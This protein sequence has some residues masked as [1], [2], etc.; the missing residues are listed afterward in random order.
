MILSVDSALNSIPE[1][2]EG[3]SEEIP[4]GELIFENNGFILVMI[5]VKIEPLF[6]SNIT[7]ARAHML[8]SIPAGFIVACNLSVVLLNISLTNDINKYSTDCL[9][10][11]T[12]A[13]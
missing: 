13:R 7:Y 6:A 10:S 2:F 12:G 11:V 8:R 9:V 3:L 1:P 5:S 4:Q